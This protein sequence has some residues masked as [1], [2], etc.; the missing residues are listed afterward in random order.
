MIPTHA[1]CLNGRIWLELTTTFR[2][3]EELI[4]AQ[5]HALDGQSE[6]SYILW[7]MPEGARLGDVFPDKEAR[8]FLQCAGSAS[9]MTIEW[10]RPTEGAPEL[11]VLGHQAGSERWTTLPWDGTESRVKENELFHA[12]EACDIFVTYLRAD[13]PPTQY[14]L[15]NVELT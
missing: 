11:L 10:S 7:R 6:Y 3:E 15:R 2:S 4:R 5:L 1:S 9:A 13:T 14:S 8:L 12:D